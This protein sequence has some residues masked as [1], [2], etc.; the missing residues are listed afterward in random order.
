MI[1][2]GRFTR[3]TA[4]TETWVS[5]CK[6]GRGKSSGKRVHQKRISLHYFHFAN[7]LHEVIS[8]FL[9]K[10]QVHLPSPS[11]QLKVKKYTRRDGGTRA[12]EARTNTA[13]E[14]FLSLGRREN[15]VWIEVKPTNAM[16]GMTENQ[17]LRYF[18]RERKILGNT[19]PEFPWCR[20]QAIHL[21]T[22][23]R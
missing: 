10:V 21:R 3:K 17:L 12:K 18:M 7:H 5:L 19:R 9:S 8:N 13:T 11:C 4:L 15:A 20:T 16:I 14:Y 6:S 22:A 2:F 1:I 23:Q